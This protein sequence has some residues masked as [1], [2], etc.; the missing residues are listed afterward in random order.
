[1][2]TM[3]DFKV[4]VQA[5]IDRA[6]KQGRPHAEI[7]AGELHRTVGGYPGT[8]HRMPLACE[9]MRAIQTSRDETV[10]APPSGNGAALTIRYV[11]PRGV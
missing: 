10:F 1:M 7:N 2:P 11:L 5:Q 3:D 9:A 8:D 4:E 6:T